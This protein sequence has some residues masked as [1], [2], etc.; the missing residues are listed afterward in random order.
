MKVIW[1]MIC[2]G[3]STDTETNNISLFNVLDEINVPEPPDNEGASSTQLFPM[4]LHLIVLF[5]R[6]EFD[7]KEQGLARVALLFPGE[8]ERAVLPEFDVRLD[9][10][11][12]HR[13]KCEFGGFPIK[14]QGEYRFQIQTLDDIGNW[15]SIFEVPLMISFHTEE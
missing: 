15:D 14:G 3:S 12:R 11:Y 8:R 9:P 10:A 7:Q 13:I 4:S 1:A 6:S 2:E 5:G